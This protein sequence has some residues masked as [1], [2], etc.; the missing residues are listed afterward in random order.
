[1][2]SWHEEKFGA[3]DA[4]DEPRERVAALGGLFHDQSSNLVYVLTLALMPREEPTD[5]PFRFIR[6]S[7]GGCECL[8]ARFTNPNCTRR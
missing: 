1:V 7:E 5:F 6:I 2:P 4:P 3:I 8:I